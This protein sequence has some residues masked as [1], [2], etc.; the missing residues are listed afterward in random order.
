MNVKII[1]SLILIG[2][3]FLFVIQNVALVNI[4][5][6]IWNLSL[7]GALLFILLFTFGTIF[8]WFLHSYALHRKTAQ[9][10]V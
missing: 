1:L 3:V 5:F 4:R 10:R 8:G 6:F 9:K 7:S 2:I